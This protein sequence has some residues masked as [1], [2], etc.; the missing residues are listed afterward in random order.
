MLLDSMFELFLLVMQGIVTLT[1]PKIP[2]SMNRV[3]YCK[4]VPVVVLELLHVLFSTGLLAELIPGLS[5]PS[6]DLIFQALEKMGLVRA[7]ECQFPFN[8][9]RPRPQWT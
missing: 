2:D 1:P 4:D 6:E 8:L 7:E 5:V 3:E 9:H